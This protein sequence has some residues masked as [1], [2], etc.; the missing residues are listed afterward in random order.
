MQRDSGLRDPLHIWHGGTAI[1]NVQFLTFSVIKY[2]FGTRDHPNVV[3]NIQHADL[4][5]QLAVSDWH[6]WNRYATAVG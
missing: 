6:I 2:E 4:I 1:E 3:L 5:G